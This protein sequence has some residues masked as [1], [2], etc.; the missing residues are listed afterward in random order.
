MSEA[1]N[2]RVLVELIREIA[3]DM[4]L[5]LRSFS[6]DWI[7]KLLKG[8][9]ERHIFGYNFEINSVTARM[10]SSD[11]SA[12]SDLLEDAGIAHVEHKLFLHPRLA[13]Y[14]SSKGNWDAIQAF[15]KKTGYPLVVK[16]NEGTGGQSVSK[17]DSQL[18]LEQSV[19]KLFEH[20]R[21]ISLSPFQEIEQEYRAIL[22]DDE[23]L[24]VYSKL[25]PNITGN[26]N[27]TVM[28]LLQRRSMEQSISQ[29]L[30]SQAIKS[31]QGDLNAI[32]K[33]DEKIDLSWKHNL[34]SGATPQIVSDDELENK[35]GQLALAA[36]EAIGLRFGSIDIVRVKGQYSVLEIN[37]GVMMEHFS[38]HYPSERTRVKEIY[39]KAVQKMFDE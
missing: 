31:Y 11:K 5:D 25:R 27:S 12:T 4:K 9:K 18:E 26:G 37:A 15:A 38:R 28:E 6:H 13:N 7:L 29:S 8:E 20:Q 30:A 14:V 19:T 23:V 22:L 32:L 10:L 34:G 33:K 36:K 39:A 21:T 1:N 2:E 35:I 3:N 16:P 17:V 24:L